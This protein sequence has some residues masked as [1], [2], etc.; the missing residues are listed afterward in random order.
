MGQDSSEWI[1]SNSRNL[2]LC[3]VRQANAGFIVQFGSR[4]D[5]F[6]PFE[7]EQKYV[8]DKLKSEFRVYKRHGHFMTETFPELLVAIDDKMKELE[9]V[10]KSEPAADS[11]TETVAAESAGGS[12]STS[13]TSSSTGNKEQ[14][15]ASASLAA[16]TVESKANSS[17]AK[18]ASTESA[19]TS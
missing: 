15:T 2:T 6:I 12:A 16:V 3:D 14:S 9:S 17:A 4:D 18:V 10:S 1:E 19:A 7:K 5:P 11:K 13:E 8:A